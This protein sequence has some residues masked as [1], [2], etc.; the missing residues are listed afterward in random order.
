[1]KNG[2]TCG[3]TSR[4][5]HESNRLSAWS[6]VTV[7]PWDGPVLGRWPRFRLRASLD[8][9]QFGQAVPDVVDVT[10][11]KA[12]DVERLE[13][14]SVEQLYNPDAHT[15]CRSTFIQTPSFAMQYGRLLIPAVRHYLFAAT[16]LPASTPKH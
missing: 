13:R 5:P 8:N 7:P 1:P 2:V 14:P 15:P 3:G 9:E 4:P 16:L 6:F 12:G 10:H 11:L